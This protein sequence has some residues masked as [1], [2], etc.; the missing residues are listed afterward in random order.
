VRGGWPEERHPA[1]A[2][3]VQVERSTWGVANIL[4]VRGQ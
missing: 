3:K 2:G 1:G 4:E